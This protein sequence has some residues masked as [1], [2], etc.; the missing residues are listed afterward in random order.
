MDGAD[1][2][3]TSFVAW[4]IAHLLAY[5][6]VAVSIRCLSM[7]FQIIEIAAVRSLGS[8]LI[9]GMILLSTSHK[10][11]PS[12]MNLGDDIK[13]S[14]LHLLGSLALIWSVI[15]LPL[16]FVA[17]VEFSGPLFAAVIVWGIARQSPARTA[18]VGLAMIALGCITLLLQQGISNDLR[19]VMPVLAVMFLTTTNLMLAHLAKTRRVTAI[20]FVMH[21]IQFP[22]YLLILIFLSSDWLGT[23]IGKAGQWNLMDWGGIVL[24]CTTLTIAGFVTQAAL[25]N[26]S[27]HSTPLQ[28]CAADALRLPLIATIGFVVFA[29]P[30]GIA[31]IIPGL[32][33]MAGSIIAS[34]PSKR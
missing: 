24:A 28:L 8:L 26:A 12:G 1:R 6:A 19:F 17:T 5:A 30:L 7:Y 29:E 21:A 16:A 20:I 33:I 23:L 4:V 13:R 3:F 2:R 11:K 14:L 10:T 25:A 32:I 18:R 27:R 15:N 31:L 34:L 22:A 9:A